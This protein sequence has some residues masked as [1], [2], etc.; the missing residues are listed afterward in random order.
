MPKH[1]TF[2]LAAS[3]APFSNLRFVKDLQCGLSLKDIIDTEFSPKVLELHEINV[4]I[5]GKPVA[6]DNLAECHPQPGD[7]V[8]IRVHPAGGGG[9]K[10]PLSA[11]LGIVLT[12]AT[13]G[14][15]SSLAIGLLNSGIGLTAGQGILL[16]KIF[17]FAINAVGKLI[18]SALAPPPKPK[19]AGRTQVN[20]AAES[21]TLF[22][23]GASNQI[24]PYGVVPLNLGVNRVYPKQAARPYTETVDNDQYVRQ[25]FCYGVAENV[26][27]SEIKIGETLISQ[28]NN[29]TLEHKLAGDLKDGTSIYSND[30]FQDSFNSLLSNSGGYVT[31]TAQPDADELIVDITFD[32][33][34][35]EFNTQGQRG[36]KSVSFEVQYAPTGTS[37]WSAPADSFKSYPQVDLS[38][39]AISGYDG[40]GRDRYRKDIVV[41]NLA[42]GTSRIVQGSQ[43]VFENSLQFLDPP[44]V[45]HGEHLLATILIKQEVTIAPSTT[46]TYTV[47]DNRSASL[48]SHFQN[49]TDFAVTNPSSNTARVAAGGL[50]FNGIEV[51]KSTTQAFRYSIRLLV[52][53]GTYDVRVRRL[54]ADS[55]SDQ[56]FDTA[57]WTAIKTIKYTAP[58]TADNVCGTGV[59]IKATDQLSGAIEQ[60]NVILSTIVPDYDEGTDSWV[61]RVSSN[62]ASLYRYILQGVCNANPL[63]DSEINLDDLEAWH[64]YCDER[65]YTYNFYVDYEASVADLLRDIAAAGAASPTIVDGKYTVVVD[66]EKTDIVQMVT[67]A[68]SW[69]YRG[70][71]QYIDFPHA[72]RVEFRNADKGYRVDEVI[73]YDDGYNASNA[74]IFERL[75]YMSA[76]NSDLAYKHARRHLATIR[77]RPEQHKFN[78]DVEN[79]VAT[80]GDRITLVNDVPLIGVG[81]GRIISITDDGTYITNIQIDNEVELATG[82]SYQ[83]R[84][85]LDDG[86]FDVYDIVASGST[87]DDL[88]LSSSVLI[89]DAPEIENL[90][91][92]FETGE[93]LDLVISEIRP[94]GDLTAEITAFNYSPGIF[95]AETGTIPPFTSI[96]TLPFSHQQPDPPLLD[97]SIQSN[98]DVMTLNSDGSYTSRMV[99]PIENTNDFD[100]TPIVKVRQAGNTFYDPAELLVADANRVVITGL[101]DGYYYDVSIV[102][103][104]ALNPTLLSLPLALNNIQFEGAIANPSDVTGFNVIYNNDTLEFTWTPNTDK[105]LSHYVIRQGAVYS[106]GSWETLQVLR[107]NI[108]EV[109]ISVPFVGGTYMIK[110]VDVLGN[111]SDNAAQIIT[112]DPGELRNVVE[113]LTEHSAF[114]GNKTNLNIE[115]NELRL[116]DT[117][118]EGTYEFNSAIDLGGVHTSSLSSAL[119]VGGAFVNNLYDSDDL[120]AEDDLF[121]VGGGDLFAEAD[122]F[123]L[124]DMYGINPGDWSVDLQIR[125]TQDDPTGSPTWGAWETLQAGFKQF[126]GAE[127]RLKLYSHADTISPSVSQLSVTVDMPD[128][129]I[130]VTGAAVDDVDG[131]VVLYDGAF[132][133]DPTVNVTLQNGVDGDYFDFTTKKD[134]AG[135]TLYVKDSSSANVDRVVDYTVLGYGKVEA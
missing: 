20:N 98:E 109:S 19:S 46:H 99:I 39:N 118:S 80:R 125:T 24:D 68:N 30:V 33:G 124:N 122:L 83:I 114:A 105:D 115:A 13:G 95:S 59:R 2:K 5:N 10:N 81:S 71:M 134:A 14:L 108:A 64:I 121:G 34:L 12:L 133:D 35:A 110:A 112:Y 74:T 60:Y 57:F 127:F 27:I 88:E 42:N 113:T 87:T 48:I 91:S 102:Y 4:M 84:I 41:F 132:K 56:I 7:L 107:D 75:E 45:P 130:K 54:T 6:N 116:A 103:K 44:P 92:V 16:G 78:M 52:P 69:G 76:T 43:V 49:S 90:V 86:T 72:F 129:I 62:P 117:D 26:E 15:G 29:F 104:N 126:W 82:G 128:R 70:S 17:D 123:A 36:A 67:P 65:G 38:I 8:N 22:I 100:V 37:D 131:L 66:K 89:A 135:F 61:N 32:R 1:Q 73:V 94:G 55:A 93:E 77:L 25:L 79:L 21:P 96:I 97:G 23:E 111:E 18:I 85:R 40:F 3:P 51:T 11:V 31:R 53:N 106:G 28:Y 58:V 119:V 63:A 50:K 47:T 120:F 9:G 101:E